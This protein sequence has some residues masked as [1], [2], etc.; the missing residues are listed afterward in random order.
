MTFLTAIYFIAIILITGYA[1]LLN[2]YHKLFNAIP[3]HEPAHPVAEMVSVVIPARNEEKNIGHCIDAIM[4]QDY[5][6]MFREIVVADDQSSDNTSAIAQSK[7]AVLVKLNEFP[8][9][10]VAYK[11]AA[12]SAAIAASHGELII[13]SDADCNAPASW[14]TTMV[15]V[16][17]NTNAVLV[18]GPVRMKYNT[19]VLSKFQSLDFAILQGITAASVHHGFHFMG[20]GAN[21]AYTKDAFNKVNGFSGID[22]IASG[23]DMLL[24]YK[25]GRQYPGQIAYAFSQA[26]MV[27]TNP[28]PDL[29]SFLWQRIRWAS[30]ARKFEDKSIFKVLLLV[31]A[32]N[33]VLLL[34]ICIA[35]F[36]VP[37]LAICVG[38]I[39]YKTIVEWRFVKSVL[40]FFQLG[41]L[42]KWFIFFQPFHIMYT[43][44]SGLFGQAGSYPWKGRQVK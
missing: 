26:A 4:Q 37:Q 22:D 2:H 27:E 28:E 44:V 33:V 34:L 43:V 14:I 3:N 35:F 23:D 7:G 15:S 30:K 20:N 31:Y 11:K 17:Q 5:P 39:L 25:I 24:M 1:F 16:K 8:P 18:A 21:M 19:S 32:M 13:T 12:L 9:G 6:L 29:K 40:R 42:M 41:Q 38:L 10:T 36:G